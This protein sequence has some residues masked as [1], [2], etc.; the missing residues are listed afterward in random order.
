MKIKT[1]CVGVWEVIREI[2]ENKSEE[3][4]SISKLMTHDDS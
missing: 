1:D 3:K 4:L 2:E